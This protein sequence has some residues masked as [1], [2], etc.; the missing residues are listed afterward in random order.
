MKISDEAMD[1]AL[2]RE[3]CTGRKFMEAKQRA[4]ERACAQEAQAMR[5]HKSVPGLGKCVLNIPAHEFFLIRE[6]Y[7]DDAFSDR[8][9]IRDFQRLEPHLAVHKA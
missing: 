6:K 1:A 8:G 7:G 4:R 9:F 3:L 2:L 5:G